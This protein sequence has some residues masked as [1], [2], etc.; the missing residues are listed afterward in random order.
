TYRI[1]DNSR[2]SSEIVRVDLE[3][4]KT[5]PITID[6]YYIQ[7]YNTKIRLS[8]S[9]NDYVEFSE[10]D[11]ES[12]SIIN[13]PINGTIIYLGKGI[14][15]YESNKTFSGVD[16]FTYRIMD[17]NGNWSE[18]ATVKIEVSGILMPNVITPNGDGVNDV[19]KIIG[20]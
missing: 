10:L 8:P 1:Y 3:I 12:I 11:L 13:Q 9:E 5:I 2:L 6:D 19:F 18:P 20:V 15:S 17:K 14:F 7:Y 4:I 16:E